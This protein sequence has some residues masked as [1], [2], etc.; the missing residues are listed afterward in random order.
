MK[1]TLTMARTQIST[2]ACTAWVLG[3][4]LALSSGPGMAQSKPKAQLRK[5][6]PVPVAVPAPVDPVLTERDLGVAA[7]VHVGSFPCDLGS[8]VRLEPDTQ[9][10]GF[11]HL[12]L[13]KDRY[14]MHPVESRTGAIRL[15]DPVQ[16]VVWI[17]LGNKSMLMSQKLGRR[18]ADEC[19]GDVQRQ[20]AEALK[21][22]PAPS[23]FEPL[24]TPPAAAATTTG[25]NRNP[26]SQPLTSGVETC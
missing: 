5:A 21:T 9:A 14:R 18:L 19:M 1:G 4:V 26:E 17:Q 25:C 2:S 3:A 15:E 12:H 22:N 13:N 8:T 23:L 7:R 10:N 24:P 11:F 6:A 16:G 20:V